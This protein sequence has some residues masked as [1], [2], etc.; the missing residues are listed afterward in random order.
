MLVV[1]LAKYSPLE[2]FWCIV[3]ATP[4]SQELQLH[5]KVQVALASVALA[6]MGPVHYV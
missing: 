6:V 5:S 2:A 4:F 1:T 3:V